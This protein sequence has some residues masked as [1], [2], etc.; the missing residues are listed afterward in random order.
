S[1]LTQAEIARLERIK[2][3]RDQVA[4]KLGFEPTLIA[5]RAQLAQIARSPRKLDEL[6]LPW[7]ADLLRG[8]PSLQEAT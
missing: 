5:N 8:L 2:E 4:A 6:L 3:D 1:P 7:Q